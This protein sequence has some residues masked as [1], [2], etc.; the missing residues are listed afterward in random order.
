MPAQHDG[1]E[2]W[3]AHLRAITIHPYPYKLHRSSRLNS[4]G[5][6]NPIFTA[7][8]IGLKPP[9]NLRLDP[10]WLGTEPDA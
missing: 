8:E 10:L 9:A 1:V 7:V 5:G 2:T 3:L 4:A 6:F